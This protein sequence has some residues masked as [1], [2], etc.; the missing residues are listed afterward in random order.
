M[1]STLVARVI[2]DNQGMTPKVT[3]VELANGRRISATK[4]I[5]ISAGAYRTPQILLLS[6]IGSSGELAQHG[7]Q[8]VVDSPHVGQNLHDHMSV[9]QW[10][11][12]KNSEAGYALGSPLFQNPSFAKGSPLDWIVTL[13]VPHNG[14]KAALAKDE[15]TVDDLHPLLTPARPHIEC[16]TLY[17]G[18]NRSDPVIPMDGSHITTIVFGGL[19]TSRGSVTLASTDPNAAPIID[20]NYFSTEADRFILRKGMRKIMEAMLSTTEGKAIIETETVAAGEKPVDW[21]AQDAEIDERIKAR[22]KSALPL[23]IHNESILIFHIT[24]YHPAETA[25]MG[26]VVDT[27]LCVYG[28]Q[29]LRV[30]DASV[31]PLP[32]A[33]HYQAC[34][35]TLAEQ[36]AEIIGSSCLLSS[37]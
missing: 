35:Y 4:E 33:A 9:A 16:F 27:N 28:V 21:K 18:T 19:P 13:P 11:K 14:L 24:V 32:I 7:V 25:V 2:I 29:G 3:A 6:G 1:T 20:P 15:G 36:A 22:G 10:W 5:I 12:L 31:I 34:T 37:E 30:V 23:S 8:Q 17:V 26:K